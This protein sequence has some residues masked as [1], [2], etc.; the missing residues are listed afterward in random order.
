MHTEINSETFLNTLR[1]GMSVFVHGGS[2]TPRVLLQTLVAAARVN[3]KRF[4]D[5]ELIHLHT[6]GTTEYATKHPKAPLNSVFRVS[7]L[8]VGGAMRAH[9]DY[10]RVDY[11]PCFLSEIPALFLSGRK[12]L[13][14]AFLSV[15]PPDK[16]GYCS[17]GTSVDVA[18]AAFEAAPII[19]AQI[20]QQMPRVHGDGFIHIDEIDYAIE[21]DEPLPE[22]HCK[23]PSAIELAIGQNVATL[24][25]DCACLQVGIGS[26]P[27]AVLQALKSRRHLGVHS[28]MWSDG[29]LDLIKAGAVDNSKKSVHAG[30]SVSGFIIGS[31]RVY[32]FI[33]DNPAVIQLGIDYVNNPTTI[34][35]NKNVAAINSAVEVD[36][37]GQVC[38]DSVGSKIISGVGGQMDFMRGAALSK[39]GKPIIAITSETKQGFSRIVP[40]LKAGAGV[41]TTRAH[42]HYI[43][44]EHGIADL[45]GKTLGERAKALITIASP[46]H[47]ESLEKQW[48]TLVR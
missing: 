42:V 8:F 32:D 38:A 10:N 9:L 11:L 4:Q 16:N 20:N 45:Y 47:R 14:A 21:V 31:K 41:V 7:N 25:D 35:R 1:P 24:I 44:T 40:T 6:E 5:I 15:S 48:G 29:I 22:P 17:L 13:D 33:H 34:A 43:V 2:A 26:I 19:I 28:E 37:T 3:P 23:Q 30:K 12:K 46:R 27:N 18:R 39:G 36:L